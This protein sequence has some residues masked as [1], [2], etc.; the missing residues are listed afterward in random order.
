MAKAIGDLD[1]MLFFPYNS[2]GE[3]GFEDRKYD[4][5]DW[6]DY[7]K[8][9]IGNGV[10]PNPA[11]NLKVESL[12]NFMVLTIRVGSAFANGRLYM[13]R[14]NFDFSVTP[15]HL[16]LG[17]RDI[18]VCRHDSINR[19]MQTLYIEGTPSGIPVAPSIIRTDDVYDLKLCEITVNAN[20]QAITQANILDTRLNP[21]VCGIV[22]ALIDQV[23]TTNIFNQYMI[24]LDEFMA[25]QARR[26]DELDY[27]YDDFKALMGALNTQSFLLINN[28]FDDWS[29]KRGCDFVTKFLAD[30]N[31]LET[32]T[33]VAL[34]FELAT[35]KT[36]FLAN[37]NIVTTIHFNPWEITEGGNIIKTTPFTI[38]RTT[39]FNTDGSIK[40][41]VR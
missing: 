31:I 5:Q 8:Q 34:S 32:A 35:R 21:E 4:S 28:N 41:V 19:T 20:A 24:A 27:L 37:G 9:F 16:T 14:R 11:N 29:T 22:H 6:A 30:G 40:E 25:Y 7:F 15:A 38:T 36:E 17:R 23:D 33:V 39:I 18:V 10:F 1:D 13:S 2:I 3:P 12:Y 26:I